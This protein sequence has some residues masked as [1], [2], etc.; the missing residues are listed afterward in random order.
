MD[1]IKV[2]LDRYGLA[3]P[4]QAQPG[5]FTNPDL[6][7][8]YGQLLASGSQSL[9]AAL[10]AG[11]AVEEIDILDL[12]ER[13]EQTDQAD[14]MGV[15]TNLV[16]A[17]KITC[18][19]LSGHYFTRLVKPTSHSISALKHIRPSW[20]APRPAVVPVEAGRAIQTG[21]LVEAGDARATNPDPACAV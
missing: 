1:T 2:L 11:G 18:A 15:Y 19:P 16:P 17:P 20:M 10:K 8:L 21:P 12:Q 4:A 9:G 13:L 7:A 6:Q 5:V 3:D 14:I